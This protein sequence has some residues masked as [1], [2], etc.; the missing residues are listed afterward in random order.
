M[1]LSRE[2]ITP[3]VSELLGTFLLTF[4]VLSVSKSAIGIP[5]FVSIAAGLVLATVVVAV[6]KYSGAHI[7]PAVT[8]GLWSTKKIGTL[9]ALMYIA[10]QF[11]GAAFA[12]KLY[13]YLIDGSIQGIATAEF[14]WR[15]FTAEAVGAFVFTF[16]LASA[17]YQ[18]FEDSKLAVTAGVSLTLG[19]I[20]ASSVSNG[21]INPA[22]ALG[23]QSWSK[24]Y[25]IAPL[26]GG[27]VG[28]NLYSM[29]FAGE[30]FTWVSAAKK[31]KKTSKA[32]VTKKQSTKKV[33]S[34][35]KT[36]RKK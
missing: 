31:P 27:L 14:D 12:W 34:K 24:V 36:K 20:V 9:K 19:I 4:V 5:Y 26:V 35:S 7:N 8:F 18:K 29:L 33:S 1:L 23:I 30:N 25:V 28:F 11:M 13:T 10:V 2:K 22:V 32:K 16:G 15:I 3:L 6:G 17:I 21:V